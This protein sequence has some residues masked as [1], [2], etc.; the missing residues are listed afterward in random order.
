MWRMLATA[1]NRTIEKNLGQPGNTQRELLHKILRQLEGCQIAHDLRIEQTSSIE[2]FRSVVPV[3]DYSFYR[4]YVRKILDGRRSIMFPGSPVCIAQT[5]GTTSDPKQIPLG[6]HLIRSYRQFNLDMAFCY[7]QDSDHYDILSDRIFPVVASPEAVRSGM[8]VPV[9]RATGVMA[10]IAP[11]P[12][13]RR[14]VPEMDVILNTD[15]RQK[16]EETT[17]RAFRKRQRVRMAAGLTPYL[18]AAFA[19]LI[20]HARDNSLNS[21]TASDIFPHLRVAFHGGTTFDLYSRKMR[22]LAGETVDHR[23]VYSA[24]EGPIAFQRTGASAGL[25]PALD[26]VFFEFLPVAQATSNNSDTVLL[27]EVECGVPYYILLTTQGGLLRYKIGDKVEF[28]ENEPPLMR[29][30]GR[31]ED[32]IDLSSEKMGVDD[33]AKA[34][35][36]TAES[37]GLQIADFLVCPAAAGL[38]EEQIAHEWIIECENRP[39]DLHRFRKTLD[40]ALFEH[41]SWYQE[42]R[43]HE[44][45]LGPPKIRFVPDGTFQRYMENE[46]VYGQQKM[47]HMH[48]DRSSAERLLCYD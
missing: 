8:D 23:N 14:Y 26:A 46:L 40:A 20:N 19:N 21:Q 3:T 47:F 4:P 34:L 6:K 31:D 45:A 43:D 38:A 22:T 2:R 37:L 39:D 27:E 11:W 29:V 42:L 13:R 15:T 36:Q 35:M 9:G 16:I 12:L 18:L 17:V 41:N 25:T 5:G 33:A 10:Q 28:I 48:N 7:M 32:Q 1:R 30:L 44:F 24:A